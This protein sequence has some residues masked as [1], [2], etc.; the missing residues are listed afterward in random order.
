MP[1]L[2]WRRHHRLNLE[3]DLQTL[4]GLLY[5]AVETP[6]LPPL[7]P[8]LG[9]HSR[10]LLVSQDRRHLFVTPWAASI[11]CVFLSSFSLDV[12]GCI[13][14]F[15]PEGYRR[16][17]NISEQFKRLSDFFSTLTYVYIY[18]LKPQMGNYVRPRSG[19]WN[20]RCSQAWHQTVLLIIW[21][22]NLRR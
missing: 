15:H 16:F 3:L 12:F 6:L 14:Y 5:A 17:L 10:A 9:S 22:T 2:F 1:K 4:F 13:K 19:A 21:Q 20:E 7:P 18:F 11:L 8:H